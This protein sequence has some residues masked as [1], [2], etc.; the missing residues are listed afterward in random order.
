MTSTKRYAIYFKTH[1]QSNYSREMS[2]GF[3]VFSR[4]QLISILNIYTDIKSDIFNAFKE[5]INS[6]ENEVNAFITKQEWNH[7][8]WIGFLSIFKKS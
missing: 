1:D 3:K 5:H 2:D 4:G 8:N 6:I 7:K